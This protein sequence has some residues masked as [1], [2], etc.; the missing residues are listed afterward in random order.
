ME[1]ACAWGE[2]EGTWVVQTVVWTCSNAG[3]G[4]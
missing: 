4:V 3:L 2:G 1:K